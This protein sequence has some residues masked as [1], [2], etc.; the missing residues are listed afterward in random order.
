VARYNVKP[1]GLCEGV[2]EHFFAIGTE[3]KVRH[4]LVQRLLL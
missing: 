2:E 1:V 4:P 3:K